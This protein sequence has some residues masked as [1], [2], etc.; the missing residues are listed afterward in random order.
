MSL[1]ERETCLDCGALSPETSERQTL[2]S[3]MGWRFM[4]ER[5][6]DGSLRAVWRCGKCWRAHK[7]QAQPFEPE[8]DTGVRSLREATRRIFSRRPV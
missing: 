7:A 5:G 3:S 2:T 4:R 8:P 1:H 6:P